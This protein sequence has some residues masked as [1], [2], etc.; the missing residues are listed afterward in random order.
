MAWNAAAVVAYKKVQTP[1]M[2]TGHATDA[3]S[4]AA[5][6]HTLHYT[7]VPDIFMEVKQ[8]QICYGSAKALNTCI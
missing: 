1:S 4:I 3:V 7:H 2:R 6:V 5:T 8:T